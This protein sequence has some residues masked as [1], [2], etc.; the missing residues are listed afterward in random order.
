MVFS[1]IFKSSKSSIGKNYIKP[2]KDFAKKLDFKEIKFPV[3]IRDIHKIK[4]NNSI[5]ISIFSYENKEKKSNPCIEE[6]NVAKKEILTYY[7]L[8]NDFNRQLSN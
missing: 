1:Q 3:K 6:K 4:N 8:I 5:G 7:F 2:D